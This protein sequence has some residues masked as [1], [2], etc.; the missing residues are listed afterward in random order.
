MALVQYTMT[1]DTTN[2]TVAFD[3]IEPVPVKADLPRYLRHTDPVSTCKACKEGVPYTKE[4]ATPDD[5]GWGDIPA[6]RGYRSEFA[7]DWSEWK[8]QYDFLDDMNEFYSIRVMTD[9]D[10]T[11]EE[12]RLL[13]GNIGY[14]FRKNFRGESLG[15]PEKVDVRTW[16]ASYDITKSQ[17]DDW[18]QHFDDA[19]EDARTYAVE[20]SPKRIRDGERL[21]EGIGPIALQFFFS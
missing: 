19:L 3:F 18:A 10:L 13:F 15:F 21:V 17:S 11:E 9:R 8:S 7:C 20:G 12:V 5:K 1:I 2:G 4:T 14:S 6:A 16:E